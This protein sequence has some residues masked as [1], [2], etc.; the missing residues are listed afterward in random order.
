M[1][2]EKIN[3]QF[4]QFKTAEKNSEQSNE[5]EAEIKGIINELIEKLDVHDQE[6]RELKKFQKKVLEKYGQ[7][8]FVKKDNG[9]IIVEV[10]EHK[11]NIR[12]ALEKI[13]ELEDYLN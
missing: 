5:Y 13:K 1:G 11:E 9:P 6:K 4:R 12:D 10:R 8:D 7:A 3:E 2:L